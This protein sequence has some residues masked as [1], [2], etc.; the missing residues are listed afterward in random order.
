[1]RNSGGPPNTILGSFDTSK[2]DFRLVSAM[3]GRRILWDDRKV[4]PAIAKLLDELNNAITT[5]QTPKQVYNLSFQAHF[6]FFSILP[7]GYGNGRTSRLLMNYVQQ[8][9]GLPLSVVYTEDRNAYVVAMEQTRADESLNPILEFMHGQLTKFMT[10]EI[11][12]LS[13][14]QNPTLK[15]PKKGKVG[16]ALSLL[17]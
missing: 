16:S 2:G 6:L 7:F 12:R 5:V 13:H 4:I 11:Q 8:Y 15:P 9:H 1:M 10:Q 3:A 14:Y 17:F